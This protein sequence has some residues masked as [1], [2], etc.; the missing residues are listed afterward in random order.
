MTEE[1]TEVKGLNLPKEL[2]LNERATRVNNFLTSA[3]GEETFDKLMALF[4]STRFDALTELVEHHYNMPETMVSHTDHYFNQHTEL[5]F[6]E[7]KW[8]GNRKDRLLKMYAQMMDVE[9][10][11]YTSETASVTRETHNLLEMYYRVSNDYR[12]LHERKEATTRYKNTQQNARKM[13]NAFLDGDIESS[14][15]HPLTNLMFLNDRCNY[16]MVQW[17]HLVTWVG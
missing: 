7:V 12:R 5:L 16:F 8:L 6:K 1:N 15:I 4:P 14:E 3:E 17:H 2:T 9:S 10:G 13:M 11:N